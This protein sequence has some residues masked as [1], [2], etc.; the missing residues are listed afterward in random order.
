MTAN[1][2][3]F[4][5]LK[6]VCSSRVKLGNGEFIDA[7]GR[8]SVMIKT[9]SGN[10]VIHDVLYV[11]KIDQNLLSLGQM[12]ENN[13]SL[14]FK[15][16]TCIIH[17]PRGSLLMTVAMRDRSFHWRPKFEHALPSLVTDSDI[18]HKRY[19]N[20]NFFALKSM[21]DKDLVKNMPAV[22]DSS[23]VCKICQLGKMVRKPFKKGPAAR[24]TTKLQ[25]FYSDIC[26]PMQ[27]LSLGG[28]R[29]FM[30]F[31]DNCTRMC[32]IYFL[33]TKSEA[34]EVFLKFKALVENQSGEKI[35]ALRSDNGGEY[36]NS[37]FE[38]ICRDAGIN[39]QLTVPYSPQQ[40]GVCERKNRTIVEMARCLL[41]EKNLPKTFWA[42]VAST[43]VYLLNRL[44][45]RAVKHKIPIEAWSDFKPSA[46]HLRVFGSVCYYLKPAVSRQK[47]DDKV[48]IGIFIGYSNQAQGYRVLNVKT[49]KIVVSRDVTFDENAYWDWEKQG[50]KSAASLKLSLYQKE[51]P[52]AADVD[53]ESDEEQTVRGERSLEDIYN[54]CNVSLVDPTTYEEAPLQL[55]GEQPWNGRGT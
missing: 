28:C 36:V 17:D 9:P 40:N 22:Q 18:W 49:Q 54:R 26:G 41:L 25:L 46:E 20:F 24:A 16:K 29:F 5:D 32:W 55:N 4:V 11:P 39:H 1:V 6:N 7:K 47:L 35:K 31:I 13:Y 2:N 52:E 45:T 8:G 10:K 23:C 21:H 53:F 50:A 27:N 3:L 51:M 44:P 14:S 12:V 30:L 37:H 38:K 33:K 15:N 34:A 42:E 43:A 48:E 19:G